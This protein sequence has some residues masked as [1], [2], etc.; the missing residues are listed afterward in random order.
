M[1]L[2]RHAELRGRSALLGGAGPSGYGIGFLAGTLFLSLVAFRFLKTRIS[3]LAIPFHCNF[4]EVNLRFY[5]RRVEGDQVKRGVVF[6]KEFVPRPAIAWVA[7]TVYNEN[8]VAL[9]WI[10]ESI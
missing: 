6:I 4:N 9:P 1:A 5:V 8:Y 3:G 10:T 7:R 2:A